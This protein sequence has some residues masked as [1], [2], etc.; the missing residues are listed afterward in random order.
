[1]SIQSFNELF[2]LKDQKTTKLTQKKCKMCLFFVQMCRRVVI[3]Y[4][5]LGHIFDSNVRMYDQSFSFYFYNYYS[6]TILVFFSIIKQKHGFKIVIRFL[7]LVFRTT[8]SL[9]FCLYAF[10]LCF[11]FLEFFSLIPLFV[12]VCLL[13]Q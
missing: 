4:K 5:F 3:R 13:L 12:D 9:F 2:I 7:T 11:I 1:M 6:L 10:E 8:L